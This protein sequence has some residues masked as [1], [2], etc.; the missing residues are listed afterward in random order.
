MKAG[1]R[2]GLVSW[3]RIK[4][5]VTAGGEFEYTHL[6]GSPTNQYNSS[7][8]SAM[9]MPVLYGTTVRRYSLSYEEEEIYC[10]YGKLVYDTVL[11]L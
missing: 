3:K 4:S 10:T 7:L 8:N 6:M 1:E 9:L 2:P 5:V 11:V